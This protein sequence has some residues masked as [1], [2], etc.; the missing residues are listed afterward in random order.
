MND[1]RDKKLIATFQRSLTLAVCCSSLVLSSAEGRLW[2]GAFTIIVALATWQLVEARGILRLPNWCT[3][4]LGVVALLASGSEFIT[5]NIE[6]KLLSGAHLIV[7]LTWIVLLMPKLRRQYWGLMA[8]CILQLA[9]SAVLTNTP[10]FGASLIGMMFVLLWTLSV[11]SLFIVLQDLRTMAPM[12]MGAPATGTGTAGAGTAGADAAG[13]VSGKAEDSSSEQRKIR[14][15]AAAIYTEEGLQ[16]DFGEA[17][18]DFRFR[19]IVSLS[20]VVSLVLAFA[21]FAAF[22]RTPEWGGGSV[23]AGSSTSPLE[24]AGIVHRTGFT[25]AVKLG[26][27][28]SLFSSNNRV[29]QFRIKEI[30]SDRQ[31]HPDELIEALASDEL[32]FRGNAMGFYRDGEWSRGLSERGYRAG[33]VVNDEFGVNI[34]V[35]PSFEIEISQ[36][37]PIGQFAF[38]VFPITKAT[39]KQGHGKVVNRTV[40]GALVWASNRSVPADSQRTFTIHVPRVDINPDLTF[41]D[42]MLRRSLAPGARQEGIRRLE[43]FASHMFVTE[44]LEETLPNL[45]ALSRQLCFQ[46]GQRVSAEECVQKIFAHLNVSGK[47][48]YSTQLTR[49]DYS[50]DPVEDFLLNTQ[51]G[52]CEYFASAC[53][54][55]LQSVGVPARLVNGFAGYDV[56]SVT[57]QYEVTER[58]AH[59]WVEAFVNG[60]W[61]TLDPTPATSRQQIMD[62]VGQQGFVADLQL[63]F[64]DFWKGGV[65]N[66]TL[67]KQKAFFDPVIEFCKTTW[68]SIRENGLWPTLSNYFR[69]MLDSPDRWVSWQGG[70]ITFVALLLIAWF[71]STHPVDRVMGLYRR[72]A[73]WFSQRSRTER[74]VIRFYAKFCSL[75]EKHGLT[76]SSHQT[77]LEIAE[78]ASL[79]FSEKLASTGLNSLPMTIAQAFNQVRFGSMILSDE[80]TAEIGKELERFAEVLAAKSN[81]RTALGSHA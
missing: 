11:F 67:E 52:H 8:L 42:W 76:C 63:A 50:I 55:M 46:N 34:P 15:P 19:G 71:W 69:D 62:Q 58:H 24:R 49:Q 26:D 65:N 9:V 14:I 80:Q 29:L 77:A 38:A 20:F 22:P 12:E 41:D 7:Y 30:E 16:R 79:K 35:K 47:Y 40:T 60:R 3:N 81:Q 5:G 27:I 48:V 70:V 78:Q 33:E 17:W 23:F 57:Q 51:S 6:G 28:G 37:P 53:T 1:L 66:L 25:E 31:V 59:T 32:Y 43:E 21:V 4:V 75:C 44:G 73:A 61:L 18:V 54:L 45:T 68:Q 64:S 72:I 10:G 13:A 36:D 2:P 39:A 56:N 74:S